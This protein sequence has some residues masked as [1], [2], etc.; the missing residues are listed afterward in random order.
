MSV[1]VPVV[2]REPEPFQNR[3]AALSIAD[4]P[5]AAHQDDDFE[6]GEQDSPSETESSDETLEEN[7]AVDV[8]HSTIA[9]FLNRD[10]IYCR[11]RWSHYD[12]LHNDIARQALISHH[13][14]ARI[15]IVGQPPEDLQ[16]ASTRP[17]II[18]QPRDITE[19]STFQL[20]LV[21]VEFHNAL[22]SL[23]PENVRRV[24][25]LPKTVSRQALI[26]VL[27]LKPYCD[28]VK[29]GCLLW[30]N[31]HHIKLQ[32]RALLDLRHGDY[33]KIAIPPGRGALRQYYT[34][35]VA[36][37]MRFGYTASNIPP[38][39][40]AN[41]GGIDVADM[42][43]YDTFT[44]IPRVED[45]DYD[46]DAMAMF[47]LGGPHRPSFDPWPDFVTRPSAEPLP[48]CFLEEYKVGESD[49]IE[50][51]R[52][53]S[54]ER[55]NPGDERQGLHFVNEAV[56]LH[57][58]HPTWAQYAAVEVEEEGRILYIQTWYADHDRFPRCETPRPVRL[59]ADPWGWLE[60]IAAVWDDRADPDS[61]FELYVVT[62]TPKSWT[63]DQ[64]GATPHVL[65]LQNPR[66][67][68][69]SIHVLS[70]DPRSADRPAISFVDSA[71]FPV[72]KADF[73]P[74]VGIE[75]HNMIESLVDCA[76]WHAEY[77]LDHVQLYHISHGMS[78]IV[79]QNHLQDIIRRAAVA[80]TDSTARSST[81]MNLL[82]VG[83]SRR[84]IYLADL[85]EDEERA[86]ASS[87]VAVKVKWMLEPCQHPDFLTL[88]SPTRAAAEDE[89]R[90]WGLHAFPV[91][92]PE[93]DLLVCLQARDDARDLFDYVFVNLDVDDGDDA[94]V[95][96]SD[97]IMTEPEIMRLLYQLGFWRAVVDLYENLD[98]TVYKINFRDTKVATMG[99]PARAI[100]QSIWPEAQF[101]VDS[102]EPFFH[103]PPDTPSS[104]MIDLGITNQDLASFFASHEHCLRHDFAGM[105]LPSEIQAAINACD[106]EILDHELDRLLVY[107]D[108]SSLGA[109][110]HVAPMRAEEEGTGDTWAYV[111]LGERY[112]PPA[113]RFIGWA[114]QPVI[115]DKHHKASLGAGRVGADVAER[116]AL[117][118]AALWRLSQNWR[119]PTCFRSDSATTLGQA[120]GEIGT[121]QYEGTFGVL[122]GLFQALEAALG[123]QGMQYSHVPGHS[124][125]VWNELCDWLAKT[126]RQ[127]S[128]YCPRP[129]ICM[130]EWSPVISSLW[131]IFDPGDD[132]PKFCGHGLH[133]PPPGIPAP[134]PEEG[135]T[136]HEP[137][138]V[139]EQWD[140]FT[141]SVS[142]CT[143]N[144]NSLSAP[145]EGF[146]GK[147]D[148]I[149][150]QFRDFHFNFLGIQESK[151]TEFCSCVEEVLRLSSGCLKNQQ[152]VELWINLAQPYGYVNQQPI[153]F[154]RQDIQ[155]VYKDPRTLLARVETVYWQC[156][157]LVAYA[158]QS[159]LPLEQREQWW[160]ALSELVHR[161]DGSE[162][163]I[164][165]IDA[166]AAPGARDDTAVF[167]EGLPTSVNTPLFRRFVSE[168]DL[169]L[170]CTTVAHCGEHFTWT[171]PTG[172]HRHC[173]DYVLLSQQFSKACILSQV[174]TEFDLGNQHWDHEPTAVHLECATWISRRHCPRQEGLGF[175]P[176][177]IDKQVAQKVLQDYVPKSWST[178]IEDQVQDF[179]RHVLTGL[180]HACPLPKSRPKKPYITEAEWK[181]RVDKLEAK[182]RLRA[183]N[184]RQRDE[185][186]GFLFRAWRQGPSSHD[187]H[188]NFL[189]YQNYLWCVNLRLVASYRRSAI[190]LRTILRKAKQEHIKE[191][192]IDMPANA[193]ASRIL[194]ELRPVLGPSNLKKLK[195]QTL[196]HIKNA[197]GEICS[198]PNEVVEVWLE[199][200]RQMEGGQRL[201]HAEQREVWR[202]NLASLQLHEFVIDATELPS[203]L[204]LEAAYRRI[205]P[206]KAIGP[207][208]IHPAFCRAKPQLLARSTFNQMLK[209]AIHGQESLA[210]KGGTLCPIWKAKGPK[211]ECSAYRSILVSSFIGKSIHRS[212][213]QRQ[214]TLFEKFMQ[215]EQL[216]GRPKVPVTLGVHLGRAFMRARK[217]QGHNIAM[218]YLD[219]TEAFYRILRQ[220]VV[221]GPASDELIMHVGQR[222]GMSTD[223]M[224]ELHHLLEE[225][226]A[227]EAA[228]LPAHMRNAIRALHVDTFFTVR[229]Q[230]DVCRTQLG[231][232][233][234]DCFADVIFSY[235]WSSILR[236]LQTTLVDMGLV[237]MI[238]ADSGLCLS[239]SQTSSSSQRPFLGPTWMDDTCVCVS[240]Q[241]P[242]ALEGKI[243][244]ATGRLLELCDGHGLTPN[245]G[246]GKTEVLLLFQGHGSRKLKI[247]YFGPSS[248]KSLLILGERGLP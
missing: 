226:S 104:C 147:I 230:G 82:Q 74:L 91:L 88:A 128:F 96:T 83:S 64:G 166:N 131:L 224:A 225:P 69:R 148:F 219:L 73:Y 51:Q 210:H 157:L 162:P 47:Q 119:I 144:V 197:D 192:F 170:P 191:K 53:M 33:L 202:A 160:T 79:I 61:G 84:T 43:V 23:E 196:P 45:L 204:D 222:L 146:G 93:R 145:T 78:F 75:N 6:I 236:K 139:E 7:D 159:G 22:P 17:V 126:E 5:Q 60:A 181:I 156:W 223:L 209:L 115:Y 134:P 66:V 234:G 154:D 190:S 21:D 97:H 107:A 231:S 31:R 238:P 184:R 220:L 121:A 149:R 233:P 89:L 57:H 247:K 167:A 46:G 44:Y 125:E 59:Q 228:G 201:S 150:R 98:I 232:R 13:D 42:P 183:L 213:R 52:F 171:D 101:G 85:L 8:R 24:K 76:I 77:E 80:S 240:D 178:N 168:H 229:G 15:H 189:S 200:F 169:F 3:E 26:A 37:C 123:R 103:E 188:G 116:E 246:V 187:Q 152:G 151:S 39:L 65:V 113:I 212:L 56:F 133:A 129:N 71:P 38:L 92:C 40:E 118:W 58:F 120:S 242:S 124:G 237:D 136:H 182:K 55:E 48:Q 172:A 199:F 243:H 203:L 244:Q 205:N 2:T 215:T 50:G 194:Q 114:A 217:Q 108:G 68:H 20:V 132:I 186:L 142:A 227:L 109:A 206:N 54:E 34:R 239:Q 90:G 99:K 70:V 130:R 208:K 193:P 81:S 62:P 4:M 163:M 32:N 117:S 11:P 10:P 218:L 198:L 143:A 122:R 14:I 241:S 216:G 153:F 87:E 95:H 106:G 155:V 86:A 177:L 179:N 141:L 127:K 135:F 164:V 94:F 72:R 29:K 195:V 100:R 41:P 30:H 175:D 185:R 27:G 111:I 221:G 105:E 16:M 36:Q 158:P 245:L 25:L 63:W 18:H 110:K 1:P 211:D 12:N 235:L 214:S 165:M 28:Y 173:L 138:T 140:T 248:D 180:R 102:H 9:Y 174:V 176:T 19:G 207:D 161:R 35:E 67:T 49:R 112:D 137:S